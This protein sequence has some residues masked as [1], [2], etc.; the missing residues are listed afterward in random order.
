MDCLTIA[1][2]AALSGNRGKLSTVALDYP[3]S[4]DCKDELK[5]DQVTTLPVSS[6][7]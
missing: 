7:S 5:L 4:S 3:L 2:E 6:T 1:T